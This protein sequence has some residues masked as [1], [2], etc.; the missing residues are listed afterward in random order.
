[1]LN[2]WM[3]SINENTDAA[4]MFME[5]CESVCHFYSPG[6]VDGGVDVRP[7]YPLIPDLCIIMNVKFGQVARLRAHDEL[8]DLNF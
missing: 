2:T 5:G 1:M 7:H 4:P 6:E 3:I 8:S